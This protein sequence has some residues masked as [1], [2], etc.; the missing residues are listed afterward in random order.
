[1]SKVNVD[2]LCKLA[3]SC[4]EMDQVKQAK[5]LYEKAIAAEVDSADAHQGLAIIASLEKD[6]PTA[7]AHFQKLTL[8]QPMEGRHL[9]NLGAIHNFMGEFTKA[10]EVL[11]KAITKDKRS[12]EAYYNL[13]IAQ[14]K[15]NQSQMAMSAY[16]EAIRLN[17]KMAEAYQNLANL[18]VESANIPMAILNFKKAI[19]SQPDLEKAHLG[20]RKAEAAS[21]QPKKDFNPFGPLVQ[22]QSQQVTSPVTMARELSD[23]ERYDDRQEVKHLADEIERLSKEGLE[24]LRKTLEPAILELQRTMAEGSKAHVPLVDV[25]EVYQTA[26]NQWVEHRKSVKRKVLEL[27]AHEE[28]INAPEVNLES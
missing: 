12:A 14:R 17:P 27:R 18:Y 21:N 19:E 16:R 26:T 9:T 8:L 25:A 13:G 15:L 28:L 6:Y 23:A 7:A 11:R 20:L 3:D 22:T 1:M 10:A 2:A 4:L 5:E 24:F